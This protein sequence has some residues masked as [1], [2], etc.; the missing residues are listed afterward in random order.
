MFGEWGEGGGLVEGG[1]DLG[2]WGKE[3]EGVCQGHFWHISGP[4]QS[5]SRFPLSPV[6]DRAAR[7]SQRQEGEGNAALHF[8]SA[9]P[10]LLREGLLLPTVFQKKKTTPTSLPPAV[11]AD[12]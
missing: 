1:S 8:L 7:Q 3:R 10:H 6:C 9:P 4:F 2:S 12:V 5:A 11:E